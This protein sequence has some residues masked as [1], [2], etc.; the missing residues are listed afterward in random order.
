VSAGIDA[1]AL[2]PETTDG[3]EAALAFHR[4]RGFAEATR[5][6][7]AVGDGDRLGVVSPRAWLE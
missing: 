2:V 7:V 5:R 4:D 1:D 3:R 6:R